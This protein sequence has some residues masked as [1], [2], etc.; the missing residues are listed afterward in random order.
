MMGRAGGPVRPGLPQ[1]T[2]RERQELRSELGRTGL[3]G[4]AP[5]AKAA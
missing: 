2:E 1:I 5:T 4:R 3:L